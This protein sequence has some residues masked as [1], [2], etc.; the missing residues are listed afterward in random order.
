MTAPGALAAYDMP[1]TASTLTPF[2]PYPSSG[3]PGPESTWAYTASLFPPSPLGSPLV[4]PPPPPLPSAPP[5]LLSCVTTAA[6]NIRN[7]H[8]RCT[9]TVASGAVC[10]KEF[11]RPSELDRHT[12]TV[13]ER[14]RVEACQL[15]EGTR[16]FTRRDTL[17]R[18][19][20][21][22]HQEAVVEEGARKPGAGVKGVV[23]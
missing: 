16:T 15:C 22:Y 5:A 3:L 18:H 6:V 12:A 7:T 17:D 14:A 19:M 4:A 20:R 9:L 10:G 21:R 8:F 1:N 2:F 11:K 13:H 23:R